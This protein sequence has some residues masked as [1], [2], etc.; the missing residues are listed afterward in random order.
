MRVKTKLAEH[1][2]AERGSEGR[3]AVSAVWALA[4][5]GGIGAEALAHHSATMFDDSRVVE[6][7]GTVKEFQW[8][9]PHTWIQVMVENEKRELVEWSIE[10]GG[11]NSLSRRG[12]RPTTFKAGDV[13]LIR[14][15]PMRNGAP[16]GT[17]IGARFADG[18]TI[19]RWDHENEQ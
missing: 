12:W 10:G 3:F 15:H 11:P 9:N 17:F 5:V 13:L 6:L 18:T 19:G 8:T 14:A 2:A 4:A 7:A 1:R 16:A